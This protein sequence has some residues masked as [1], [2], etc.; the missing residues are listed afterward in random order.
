MLKIIRHFTATVCFMMSIINLP[1]FGNELFI[2]DDI[3]IRGLKQISPGMVFNYLP[4]T[5]GDTM[6]ENRIRKAVRALFKTG[7]FRDKLS[8]PCELGAFRDQF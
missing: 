2:V 8:G 6:D 7:F 5:I 3:Q 4:V 1:A